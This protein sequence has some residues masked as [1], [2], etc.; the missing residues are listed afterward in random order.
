MPPSN[1]SALSNHLAE[2]YSSAVYPRL[3]IIL[4]KFTDGEK[5]D[6]DASAS[7]SGV[8]AARASGSTTEGTARVLKR[9]R[10]YIKVSR[11][12]ERS[13]RDP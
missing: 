8:G 3:N 2:N 1:Y 12:G 5:D 10:S 7:G 4:K 11:R 9:F 13:E 6:D